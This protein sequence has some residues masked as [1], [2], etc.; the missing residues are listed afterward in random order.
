MDITKPSLLL[1][2]VKQEEKF[3][4]VSTSFEETYVLATFG[5]NFMKKVY[6]ESKLESKPTVVHI[7][8]SVF[9]FKWYA[10]L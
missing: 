8:K 2:F 3:L 1:L 7:A 6:S 9:Q 10:S 4:E 5:K